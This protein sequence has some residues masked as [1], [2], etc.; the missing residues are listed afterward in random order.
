MIYNIK[1]L[2]NNK[3]MRL[4]FVNKTICYMHVHNI[5]LLFRSNQYFADL[6]IKNTFFELCRIVAH[7]EA[8]K[9]FPCR[10]IQRSCKLPNSP[11]C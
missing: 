4:I 7:A 1:T 10:E 9:L 6:W 5:P 11:S 3:R 8:T 2:N